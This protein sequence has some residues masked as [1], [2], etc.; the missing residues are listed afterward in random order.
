MKPVDLPAKIEKQY[1]L[2]NE[3]GEYIIYNESGKPLKIDF[4]N[5]KETYSLHHIDPKTGLDIGKEEMIKGGSIIEIPFGNYESVVILISA[6][7]H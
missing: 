7:T 4:S 2:R 6:L 1:A 3:E 5:N